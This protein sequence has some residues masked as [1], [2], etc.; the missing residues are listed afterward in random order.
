MKKYFK[1]FLSNFKAFIYLVTHPR[2]AWHR[3]KIWWRSFK[4]LMRF[5][6]EHPIFVYHKIRYSWKYIISFMI[7][8]FIT[9]GW[10]YILAFGNIEWLSVIAKS[11]I[12]FLW[13]PFTPE[14]IITFPLAVIIHK[15]IWREGNER[16][17]L[18]NKIQMNL[19]LIGE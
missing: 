3:F 2:Y 19:A 7:A 10:A 9:N 4:K 16:I 14:K 1:A 15:M 13:L 12:A 17:K 18:A 5:Y 6:K 11:Y 8:W